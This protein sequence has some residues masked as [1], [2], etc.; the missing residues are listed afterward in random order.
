MSKGTR[1]GSGQDELHTHFGLPSQNVHD[2]ESRMGKRGVTLPEVVDGRVAA[3]Q[4]H[5]LC[6]YWEACGPAD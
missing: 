4:H 2:L 6:K 5:E 3:L 1:V